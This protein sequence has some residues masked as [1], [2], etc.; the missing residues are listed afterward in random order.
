KKTP[1]NRYSKIPLK[2]TI[3]NRAIKNHSML[4]EI[5]KAF[6]IPQQSHNLLNFFL[7]AGYKNGF[8]K[9]FFRNNI[10]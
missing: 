3:S 1:K 8:G 2:A 4:K 5:F 10:I 9:I 6:F 7:L